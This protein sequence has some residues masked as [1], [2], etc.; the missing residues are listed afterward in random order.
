MIGL[1]LTNA[2]GIAVIVALT[3]IPFGYGGTE[4]WAK[5][6]INAVSGVGILCWVA[7]LLA[8][9]RR[10]A[11]PSL[12]LASSMGLLALGW[13]MTLNAKA[14][15]DTDFWQY[16]PLT[17]AVDWLPGSVDARSSYQIMVR[18]SALLGVFMVTC[19]LCRHRSWMKALIFT[20]A[21]VGT[22]TAGF[23]IYQKISQEPF[24]I[25]P[26]A[27]APRS[28]FATFWYHGNAASFLNLTWPLLVGLAIRSFQRGTSH[29]MRCLWLTSLMVVF[30]GLAMNVSKAG[31]VMAIMLACFW[32][33]MLINR[34]P[35]ILSTNGWR[36][37]LALAL[38]A[39]A[40]LG[41]GLAVLDW[42]EGL[43]RWHE[44]LARSPGDS[45]IEV[46][47]ICLG[48]AGGAGWCGFGPGSFDAAFQHHVAEIGRTMG[49]RWKFAHNDYL[50]TV[51]EWGFTGAALWACFWFAPLRTSLRQIIAE[52]LPRSGAGSH[53]HSRNPRGHRSTNS[54]MQDPLRVAASLALLGVFIHVAYDFPLQIA[55]IQL[56]TVVLAGIAVS[57]SPG[58]T[59]VD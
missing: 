32:L 1:R 5:E 34:L 10:P 27:R 8:Q 47:K 28:A 53:G 13:G 9:R 37:P 19:D 18:V 29:C 22:A 26:V 7:G 2:S 46:A 49:V 36:Q 24:D 3:F 59:T 16:I 38:I 51:I 14:L 4:S 56:F 11:L 57:K 52:I 20:M 30:A 41:A 44:F 15:H 43:S 45:R 39:L 6:V 23:G 40:G 50:Q 31:H 55:G 21:V 35:A 48:L 17:Q 25:W 54:H 12:T 58:R 42:S 33:S